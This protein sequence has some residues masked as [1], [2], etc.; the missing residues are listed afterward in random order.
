MPKNS[1]LD[2]EILKYSRESSDL[3]KKEKLFNGI[4]THS[5]TKVKRKPYY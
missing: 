1:M 3:T 5:N 2:K 4:S